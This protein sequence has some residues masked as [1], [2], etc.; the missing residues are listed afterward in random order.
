MPGRR[1][2]GSEDIGAD[3]KTEMAVVDGY[4]E[5][6]GGGVRLRRQRVRIRKRRRQLLFLVQG[7]SRE[8]SGAGEGGVSC[9]IL[10]RLCTYA[11]IIHHS[12]LFQLPVSRPGW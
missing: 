2:A 10:A 11:Y 4:T 8:P 5:T 7:E 3:E 1:R 9:L 6:G 12:A